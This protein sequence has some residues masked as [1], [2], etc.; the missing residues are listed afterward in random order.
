MALPTFKDLKELLGKSMTLE[1]QKMIQE[2]QEGQLALRE[3][4]F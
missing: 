4:N 1:A 3:E 2:L